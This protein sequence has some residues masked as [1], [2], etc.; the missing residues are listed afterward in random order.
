[1]IGNFK[2][3]IV[4]L[5]IAATV[6]RFA[7]PIALRFSA[8]P[9]FSRRR[10]IWFA[11]TVTAFLSPNFWLFVLFAIPLLTWAGR[12]DSNPVALYMMLL[13]VV[14]PV[15]VAIPIVGINELFD[16]DN[17]RLLS[18]CILIPT[19]WRLRQSK[20]A[21]RIRGLQ[22]MDI[23]LLA[24]GAIQIAL[25]VPPDLPN[26]VIL[27][28]SPTDVLRRIFLFFVDVYA[29]YFA[30]SRSCSSRRAIVDTL[31]SFCVIS[32]VMALM[33][34][35]ESVRHWLLYAAL[36]THWNPADV[37][38][39][40]SYL[41]R[42]DTLRAQASAGHALALG[43]LLAIA[44]GFWLYLQS[45][46]NSKRWRIAVA[47][48][49]WLGLLAAY[50][51]GPWIGAVAIYFAFAALGRRAFSRLFRA[52]GVAVLLAG[53]ISLSPLSERIVNVLPF[54][55][56]SV[57]SEN[58]IY[59]QRLADR[60]WE[61][62]KEHPFFGDQLAY[63]KMEDLRQGQGII[64]VVNT[65][66]DAALFS[67]LIG[68][69]LFL[70][71]ILIGLFKVYRQAKEIMPLNPDFGLLG[72]S[73]V[74][75][76]LGTLLMIENVSFMLGYQKLFY[77]LAGLAAAYVRYGRSSARQIEVNASYGIPPEPK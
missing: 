74:S 51:R 18:F 30:V 44:F 1:M 35:F 71:F 39:S 54:M 76:I 53:V 23:F 11:L 3:M 57:D 33:A 27:H 73:L 17:Y 34:V 45:H 48:A 69:S 67:G 36:A 28:D 64:D 49:L 13:H 14:Q 12:K 59:R 38:A 66:A 70:G 63:L 55:G 46:V 47:L 65:Y 21:V 52:A 37:M 56:G 42:G 20:D 6:F 16:L 8:E 26:H 68:L 25:F 72:I 40:F 10:N 32:V 9:D 24:Y 7:K 50:S 22:T 29:L 31:G 58:F 60:T 43:Y 77:V 41:F 75:C 2:E 4:V 15:A 62:I 19:A 61:L 5:A